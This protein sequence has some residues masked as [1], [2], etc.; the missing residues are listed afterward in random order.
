MKQTDPQFKLRLDE[1][2]KAALTAAAKQNQRTLSAEI[3]ARLQASFDAPPSMEAVTLANMMAMQYAQEHGIPQSEALSVLVMK[4]VN[5]KNK[6]VAYL[7]V[8]SGV[9][10]QEMRQALR[11]LEEGSAPDA[12]MAFETVP[13]RKKV[14]GKKD[15]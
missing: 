5:D 8:E 9:T 6:H 13:K 11:I 3:V 2:L 14:A 7:A 10:P 1:E 4:G 15:D 12:G